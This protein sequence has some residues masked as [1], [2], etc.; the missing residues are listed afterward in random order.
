MNYLDIFIALPLII[1]AI[2]GYQKGFIKSL[3]SLV[4][5]VAGIYF[6]IYFSD[7]VA[8]WLIRNININRKYV[9]IAAFLLT[10]AGVSFLVHLLGELL[11][12][13]ASLSALGVINKV[14]GMAVG[15][16]KGVILMSILILLFNL[17]NSNHTILNQKTI[18][19][20][21]L[22]KPVESVAPIILRNIQNL[23]FE[24]PKLPDFD[25][26]DKKPDLDKVI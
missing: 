24:N 7:I 22:Y 5:L 18:S 13:I 12:N 20:S 1:A 14:G 23:D 15:A 16:L 10:F 21:L 19:D 8:D 3:T 2:S 4:A 17:V 6:A 9:F 26:Q 11:D 25:T